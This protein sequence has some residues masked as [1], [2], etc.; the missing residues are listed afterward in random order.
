MHFIDHICHKDDEELINTLAD[1]KK[2][3]NI[4]TEKVKVAETTQTRIAKIRQGYLPVA[5]LSSQLFFIISDL[6]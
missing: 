5:N 2:T 3:S 1:S 6:R 4:I